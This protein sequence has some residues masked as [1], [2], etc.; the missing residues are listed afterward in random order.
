[1]ELKFIQANTKVGYDAIFKNRPVITP[2][3][4]EEAA[5]KYI[6]NLKDVITEKSIYKNNKPILMLSGGVDSMLLGAIMNK[7]IP[8]EDSI[9]IG[10]V[11]DTNDIKVSQDSA[12]KLG[13]NNQLIYCTWDEVIDNFDL[14]KGKP[15]KTVHDIV[16]Y[17][18][19]YLCL[20]K[21]NVKERDLIQGDGADT[22]LGSHNVWPYKDVN[23]VMKIYNVPKNIA[24]TRCKQYYFAKS[25]NP[26][27]KFHNGSG[28]LFELLAKD[29]EAN[30]VLAYKD[31]RVRWIN[32]LDYD[33]SHP[34]H[35]EFPKKVIQHL[36]YDS[37]KVKRTIM[38]QGTG[39]YDKMK[40]HVC[41][42][43]GKS[44]FNSAVKQLVNQGAS[45]PI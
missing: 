1:V 35:K 39:I 34:E 29:L 23:K 18:T 17:L 26:N 21:T 16:Y 12:E 32:D 11:K 42:L 15:I 37:A 36:G 20:K 44:H 13:I 8:F 10:C 2:E 25:T 28:H 30:A 14:I 22:L 24:Q 33:F 41:Q 7:Y 38:Q 45:L 40:E 43:T 31:D 19:F 27:R 6:H 3:S 9:T 5:E 4:F